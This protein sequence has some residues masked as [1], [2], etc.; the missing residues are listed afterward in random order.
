MIVTVTGGARSG[1][2]GFAEKWCMK[3]ADSGLYIATAQAFDEEMTRRIELHRAQREDSGFRWFTVEEP[4]QVADVLCE[5]Q[6]GEGPV[7]ENA[8]EAEAR[9]GTGGGSQARFHTGTKSKPET[10]LRTEVVTKPE[11]HPEQWPTVVLVDC[12]TLWLSNVMLAADVAGDGMVTERE[13]QLEVDTLVAA[14]EAYPGTLVMV[15]NEVGSGIVPEY[16]LGRKYRDW[17]GILN[18]RMAAISDQV[19]L[20]TAGIAIELKSR[21]YK[22]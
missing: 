7:T 3:H 2:S 15:T 14:V 19:F 6:R 9:T 5:V 18:R 10:I 11:L 12:L 4:L 1:K 20:V 16:P 22:L 8:A 21:E 17:A 13:V